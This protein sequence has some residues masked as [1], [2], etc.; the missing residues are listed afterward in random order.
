[1]DIKIEKVVVG[2]IEANCYI[3]TCKKT[4]Q[5]LVID[6]GDDYEQISRVLAGRKPEFVLNTHGHIDH[7]KEDARFG[8]D[9]YIHSKDK[10]CLIDPEK[11]LSSFLGTPISI[12]A[13]IITFEDNE[14][15]KLGELALKVVHTP[16]H[17]PGSVCFKVGN[18][19]FS[20]DTLFCGGYGR[21]DLPGGSESQLLVSIK[22]VLFA[23]P[24]NTIV[25]PGHGPETS[26]ATEQAYWSN[27]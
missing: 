20:G 12:D 27:P 13:N 10:S 15:I 8:V 3:V 1:M 16:G 24:A 21:T 25:Y 5:L 4:E 14:V 17:T 11:N 26:I 7:I 22:D 6:P 2:E 18:V 19:L 9:V 23:L